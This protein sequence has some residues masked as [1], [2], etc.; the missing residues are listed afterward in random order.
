MRGNRIV[1]HVSQSRALDSILTRGLDPNYSTGG[2][3][4]VWCAGRNAVCWAILHV[5]QTRRWQID[6]MI[7]FRLSVPFDWLVRTNRPHVWRFLPEHVVP[8][9]CI[10]SYDSVTDWVESKELTG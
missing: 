8:K 3:R 2:Y 7:L 9:S 6:D 10:T 1:Y 5:A 4:S